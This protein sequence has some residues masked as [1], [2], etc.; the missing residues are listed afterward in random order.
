M[1]NK[2]FLRIQFQI[3]SKF[4]TSNMIVITAI[5]HSLFKIY[6]KYL[7]LTVIFISFNRKY[8]LCKVYFK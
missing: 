5:F 3:H 4:F 1:E 7:C 8:T 2:L 6:I